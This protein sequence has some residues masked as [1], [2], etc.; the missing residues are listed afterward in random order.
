MFAS[1]K[2]ENDA[3][4]E[5][6]IIR[7]NTTGQFVKVNYVFAYNEILTIDIP[8]R[9][10]YSNINPELNLY[11]ISDDTYLSDFHLISG[12]NEIEVSSDTSRYIS[13]T[14]EFN[15]NYREATI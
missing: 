12:E 13:V 14:I 9:R 4:E 7:N 10:L 11:C 6:I 2:Q 15:N 5:M 1:D 8:E 3:A